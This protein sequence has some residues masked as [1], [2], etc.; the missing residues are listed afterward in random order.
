MTAYTT[1]TDAETD[2]EAPLTSI[3]AK[4]WR[5]NPIAITEGSS[6]APKIQFAAMDTWFSTSGSVGS[7]IFARGAADTAFGST[8]A[9]STLFPTS[10]P[11]SIPT[12]SGSATFNSGAAQSGTWRCMGTFDLQATFG[13]GGNMLGATLWMRIA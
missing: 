4:K 10:A 12:S 9:G 5:D 6:G 1:I 7:Y 13:G 11:Y 2:P 8:V 3:L